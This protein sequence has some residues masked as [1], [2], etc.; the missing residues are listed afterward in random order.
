MLVPF[1]HPPQQQRSKIIQM[2]SLQP[3]PSPLLPSRRR[4]KI[5]QVQE[6]PHPQPLLQPQPHWV[7][8]K[9]LIFVSLQKLRLCYILFRG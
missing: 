2:Q 9:S 1:P 4:S 7:A 5:I 3:Q 8:D 6:F